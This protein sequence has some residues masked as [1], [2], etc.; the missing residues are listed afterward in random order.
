M[1][2]ASLIL[3]VAIALAM[4]VVGV[5]DAWAVFSDAGVET[6]S[7][8]LNAWAKRWPVL[9]FLAGMLADHLFGG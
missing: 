5:Y 6:V 7:S 3:A 2:K 8:I 9:P 4:L 1:D